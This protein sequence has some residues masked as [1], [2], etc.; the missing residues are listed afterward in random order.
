MTDNISF[1][2]FDFGIR[3]GR[4]ARALFGHGLDGLFFGGKLK[5]KINKVKIKVMQNKNVSTKPNQPQRH[6][7]AKSAVKT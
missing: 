2:N 3:W 1:L 6:R 7:N 4:R 5:S